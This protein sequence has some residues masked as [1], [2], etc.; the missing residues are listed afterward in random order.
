MTHSDD[1]PLWQMVKKLTAHAPILEEDRDALLALP[2]TLARY[3]AGSYLVREGDIPSQCGV[4]VDGFAYRSKLTHIGGRQI[5]SVHIPGEIID[6]QHLFLDVA[7]HNIQ[8]L[9]NCEV[10]SVSR[11]ALREL[12]RER[13]SIGHAVLINVLVEGSILREWLLSIGR[14]TARERLAHL[15]CEFAVKLDMQGLAAGHRYELPMS[16]EQLADALGLTTVHVNRT[17]RVL[18]AEGLILRDHRFVSFPRWDDLKRVSG[19]QSRY[20]HLPTQISQQLAT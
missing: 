15:L 20:L 16:Q 3:R 1:N 9:T 10:A 14:R 18:I 13:A 6:L 8:T 11:S 4:I 7:D 5:V 19:F 12:A 2:V 17:L